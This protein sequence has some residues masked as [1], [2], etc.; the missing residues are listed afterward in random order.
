MKERVVAMNDKFNS[1]LKNSSFNSDC[2]KYSIFSNKNRINVKVLFVHS[3]CSEEKIL[4]ELI[5][6]LNIFEKINDSKDFG[7][8]L[9]N[10]RFKQKLEREIYD[11]KCSM[12]R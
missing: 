7:Q 1:Y 9:C 8:N 6:Y 12:L 3:S 11:I 5:G 2:W 10:N 4:N